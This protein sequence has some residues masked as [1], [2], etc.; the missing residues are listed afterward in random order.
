MNGT[1]TH[2]NLVIILNTSQVTNLNVKSFNRNFVNSYL[3]VFT[4]QIFLKM[5]IHGINMNT[6]IRAYSQALPTL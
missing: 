3:D 6:G 4:E 5:H 1:F 2:K